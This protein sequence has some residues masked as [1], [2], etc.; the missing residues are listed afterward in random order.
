MAAAADAAAWVRQLRSRLGLTQGA[1]AEKLGVTVV[2]VNRWE[3]GRSRP[4]RLARRALA[5]LVAMADGG[6]AAV[7]GGPPGQGPAP[8]MAAPVSTSQE[9]VGLGLGRDDH[10]A[11]VRGPDFTGDAETVRLF[12]EGERLRYGH[13]F[14]RAFG[15]EISLIDPVPHQIIAVYNHMLDQP[16][17]RFLLADDAG[18]G[19]TIMTGLYIREMLNRRLIRR[20]LVIPP[21][22]LVGNWKREMQQFFALRFHEVTGQDCRAENPFL[23]PDGDLV[24]VSVDTLAA[25]RALEPLAD[26]ATPPYDLVVFDE[27]HKLSAYRNADGTYETTDR[28]KLAEMLAGAPPL[29][30]SRD[31][32]RV[33][34]RA[35][36]L[37]LLTATPHM[38]KAFPY[39]ALWRLLD[40]QAVRTPDGLTRMEPDTRKRY[41]L[42]RVKE[43]MVRFDGSRIFPTRESR[44]VLYSLTPLERQLYERVTEYVRSGYNRARQLNRSA[45][46][47]AMSV[48]QRRAAS[49]TWALLRSLERRLERLRADLEA[50]ESRQVSEEQWR[51]DQ[52]ARRVL[53]VEA[54][55][56]D[57]EAA[58]GVREQRDIAEEEAMGATAATTLAELRAECDEVQGLLELARR[59]HAEGEDTKFDKLRTLIEDPHFAGEKLL[60]FSEHRD[61]AE[62]LVRRLEAV[63]YAGKV[64]FIHGGLPY[65]LRDVQVE[66]FR[67]RCRFLVATDAAGEG[68]NL[69][70]CWIA[71]NYDVPWNP[72]RIE[73]RFGRVHRYKQQH[74][75]VLLINM[76]AA[77]TRE[78]RVLQTLLDKLEAI[79]RDMGS[80]RVFDVIGQQLGDVSLSEVI[81]RAALE[82]Q[83]EAEARR[84]ADLLS[85]DRVRAIQE[86]DAQLRAGQENVLSQLPLLAARREQE[87]LEKLLPGYVQRFLEKSAPLLGAEVAGDTNTHF[88]LKG[89]PAVLEIALEEATGGKP[90]PLTVH[91]PREGEKALFLRPG[92]PFFDAYLDY[93]RNMA[94]AVALRGAVFVDAYAGGPYF[95]HLARVKVVRAADEQFPEY[96]GRE[97]VVE[98]RLVALEQAVDGGVAECPLEQL[99]VVRPATR[100]APA[101]WP[102]LEGIRRAVEA[103]GTYLHETVGRELAA[104]HV[105][106]LSAS[107]EKREALLRVAFDL[108]E[109]EL[110]EA[111]TRLKKR[112]DSG[113]AEAAGLL[114]LLRRKQEGLYA[115]RE[116][117]L[118]AVGREPEL[119][120]VS[121][122][123]FLAHAL[124][125]PSSDPVE[126]EQHDREIER[127]AV[128]VARAHE[129]SCGAV[130]EDVSAPAR[131]TGFDLLS[132]RPQGQLRC[133]EVK[134]RRGVG[135]VELTENEWAKAA[136]LRESYWLYVVYNC[137]TASPRL[138]RVQDPFA[139]LLVRAKGGVVIDESSILAVAETE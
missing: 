108:Q 69:Q 103:V 43:D 2:T 65:P 94:A 136:N 97:V 115:E 20:V 42:R 107:A 118:A 72:A 93:F 80:D 120:R 78:G 50:L 127:I 55:T 25:G 137:A 131:R 64:A 134:G 19:K 14:S 83:P 121:E 99:M 76:V 17:L 35:R 123:Q 32:P 18:A 128:S 41:F 61:T 22:G 40:P 37:L 113:D 135:D 110:L 104:K 23:P 129:E 88:Y 70:F 62:F 52:Q 8:L 130:V 139:R 4:N 101:S 56:G 117:A 60:I 53:D 71:V 58:E 125:L 5:A 39:F 81:M 132:R 90:I 119:V 28:Y 82:G 102:S 73:Q 10:G 122:V 7:G 67:E 47:V 114:G 57:E 91:R 13:L 59:V 109:A 15:T 36:H 3:M 34:W 85:A 126:R 21:A 31:R 105:R 133:I 46:K 54:M 6:S 84:I 24:V 96:L 92:E 77:D 87:R 45:A 44:T 124:V 29:Q 138:V 86:A 12:V 1:L 89:L 49:S 106:S 116:Q 100:F 68:I 11:D 79:R 51:R 74:D 63:G 9:Q 30:E 95:F 75:P 33:W 112:A 26:S 48:L 38:G 66:E 27:A 111:R 16:R 98:E